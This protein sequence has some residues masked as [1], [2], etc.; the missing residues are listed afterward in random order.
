M[1]CNY[2]IDAIKQQ[3]TRLIRRISNKYL[4]AIL[5]LITFYLLIT[6]QSGHCNAILENGRNLHFTNGS[7]IVERREYQL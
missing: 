6:Y 7:P 1:L 2:E 4:H 3:L 5:V